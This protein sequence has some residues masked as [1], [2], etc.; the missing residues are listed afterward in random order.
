[1]IDLI[2]QFLSSLATIIKKKGSWLK[3]LLE[4]NDQEEELS[5]DN[6]AIISENPGAI[7][8]N[9]N[10]NLNID[11][12]STD[13]DE[14]KLKEIIKEFSNLIQVHKAAIEL[15]KG[16]SEEIKTSVETSLTD[17]QKKQIKL[18]KKVGWG[19]DKL[20]SLKTAFKIINIEDSGNYDKA[21]VLMDSAFSGRKRDFNRKF[22]NLARAGFIDGF[23]M[24][25]LL[26]KHD[27]MSDE[28]I[29]K[30]LDYFP[31]AIFVDESFGSI[32]LNSELRIRESDNVRHVSLFARGIQRIKTLENAYSEYIKEKLDGQTD[33]KNKKI[34]LYIIRSR[35]NYKIGPI[36]AE[37]LELD[38]IDLDNSFA[39]LYSS[40]I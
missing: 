29:T 10:L 35:S 31:F 6:L 8:N 32:R 12:K 1:M 18:F 22:Y 4:R 15:D 33:V 11:T 36:D 40:H 38:L 25:L 7:I 16:T 20:N 14:K 19:Q 9:Y 26:E 27:L 17:K 34:Q 30:I 2:S 23:A 13:Y 5:A 21:M 37:R 28:G 39:I 24:D 3:I